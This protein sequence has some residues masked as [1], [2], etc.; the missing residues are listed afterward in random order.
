LHIFKRRE[1]FDKN[2]KLL[3]ILFLFGEGQVE[4]KLARVVDKDG[5]TNVRS[6]EGLSFAVIDTVRIDDFF[7]CE[8]RSTSDWYKVTLQKWVSG[9][10]VTGYIHKSR[11]QI[12]EDLG[13]EDQNKIILKVFRRQKQLADK[14]VES[15]KKYNRVSHKWNNEVDSIMGRKSVS[16]LE[17]YSDTS[18]SPILYMSAQVGQLKGE[19]KK[20]IISHIE[21]GL[22]NLFSVDE[23]QKSTDPKFLDLKKATRRS[24]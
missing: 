1:A 17:Y 9:N 24:A 23:N 11:I 22:L 18:Y 8:P 7:Y 5:F 21:W 14:F 16:E 13:Y 4:Q 10:Q 15:N 12:I 2:M 20:S 3:I 19:Q 6:G